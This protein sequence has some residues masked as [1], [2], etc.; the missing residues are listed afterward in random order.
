MESINRTAVIIKPKQPFVD[1]LN[2]IPEETI[3]HTLEDLCPENI[4][5]LIPEYDYPQQSLAYVKKLFPVL[6]EHQLFGWY[7]D[8][9]LWPQK[10]TWKM[11]Q[12]WFAIEI[13][14]EVIDLVR[15]MIEKEE[16]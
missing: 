3:K 13:N 6:F 12:E 16:W 15:G 2:S 10:R 11:F 14:S 1:W 7:T 4:T 5:Y 8:E 9:T